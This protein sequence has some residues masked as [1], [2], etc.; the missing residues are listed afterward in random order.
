M[1]GVA[2]W[3]RL[4]A[5]H[6]YG[7]TSDGCE[8]VIALRRGY[9]PHSPYVLYYWIGWL[10]HRVFPAD[11][12]L[13]VLSFCVGVAAPF[14][15]GWLVKRVTRSSWAGLVAAAV[16]A[17]SPLCVA[18]TGII[19]V[20]PLQVTLLLLGLAVTAGLGPRAAFTGALIYGAAIAAHS[21]SLFAFPAFV[22]LLVRKP[23]ISLRPNE[24]PSSWQR[25]LAAIAGIVIVPALGASWLA[26]LFLHSSHV[27]P[28]SDW[29]VYL[30]GIAPS[31]TLTLAAFLTLPREIVHT[32]ARMLDA[33]F[34][35]RIVPGFL[36]LAC[37]A[38]A[39]RKHRNS[40][41]LWLALSAPYLIYE[42]LIHEVLDRGIY[43]VF[44]VPAMAGLISCGVYELFR[45]RRIESS[46]INRV[47]ASV[48]VVMLMAGPLAKSF[49][50]GR[51]VLSRKE[52]F[53]QDLLRDARWTATHLSQE[54]YVL[55]SPS[56][57]RPYWLACYSQLRGMTYRHGQY[58]R[59]VGER[60]APL[61]AT[62]FRP[63]TRNDLRA[64]LDNGIAVVSVVEDSQIVELA[65]SES[66]SVHYRWK[67]L[68]E[69]GM[70]KLPTLYSLERSTDE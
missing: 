10:L 65:S 50:S 27:S 42:S 63:L 52:F 9:L 1:L 20:Y 16:Y 24:S 40:F 14:V 32:V 37:A 18:G 6:P 56:L 11:I 67:R 59:F 17:M 25:P 26:L 36:L 21:G 23:S 8:Y 3:L 58:R 55:L 69:D 29:L 68:G 35:W 41:Y 53:Q 12:A 70:E 62:S 30:R 31:P 61:N 48:A 51:N 66:G 15:L 47:A 34:G 19:E 60:W 46:R 38:V 45:N 13:S 33:T 2:L 5:L 43:T 44:A 28:W 54:S 4:R 39:W 49:A 7:Y 64:I 22:Y 57:E